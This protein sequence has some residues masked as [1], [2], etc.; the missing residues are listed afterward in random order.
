MY[1]WYKLVV[2]ACMEVN[3]SAQLAV[4]CRVVTWRRKTEKS[5]TRVGV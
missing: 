3:E 4:F 5:G 1:P 2:E